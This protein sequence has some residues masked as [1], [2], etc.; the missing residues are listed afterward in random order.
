MRVTV[1][2][3]RKYS[4]ELQLFQKTKKVSVDLGIFVVKLEIKTK[5]VETE[6]AHLV[7]VP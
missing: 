6:Q 4:T 5:E 2:D 3:W 7:T 1:A